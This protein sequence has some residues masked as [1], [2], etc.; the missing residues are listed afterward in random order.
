MDG[1]CYPSRELSRMLFEEHIEPIMEKR[2]PD[3]QFAAASFGM[4]SECLGL[5]NEISMDHYVGT[6]GHPDSYG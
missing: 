3:I 6:T 5:D 2:Y 1:F 4:C